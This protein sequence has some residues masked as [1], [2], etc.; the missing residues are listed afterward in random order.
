MDRASYFVK[1]RALFG[2]FP[3]QT[4]VD[5]LEQEGV[6]FFV[7]LT[8]NDERK[9]VPYNTKYTYISFP[10]LDHRTPDD[11]IK[12]VYFIL[13]LAHIIRHL[14]QGNMLY[15]HCKGGHGRSGVVVAILLCH[16]FNISPDQALEYTTRYHSKRS[17][18]RDKWRKL[19]S[20]QTYQQKSFVYHCCK[21][22]NFFRTFVS[23]YTGGFSNFTPHRVIIEGF[24]T[25]HTAEAAIQAYKCPTDQDYVYKQQNCISPIM[26][27]N[28]GRKVELRPDWDIVS[29]ELM[30]KILRCKFDQHLEI[31]KSLMDTKLS[32]IIQ[33]TRG[34]SYWGDSGDGS[35]LNIL[36]IQLTRLRDIY[37]Q[38]NLRF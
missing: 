35:G 7:D 21:P 11:A 1:S 19:G 15:L 18:M 24:G 6:R 14:T 4:A 17:V 31:K 22:I 34:D 27:R 29:S 28:M 20:P 16:M 12:F 32:P 8:Y 5:E 23:G 38:E 3:T 9:I 26:A 30:F 37:Y 2:S 33:H 10:I 36:G 13:Q 25:F